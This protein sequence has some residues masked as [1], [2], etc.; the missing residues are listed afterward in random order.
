[1][2]HQSSLKIKTRIAIMATLHTHNLLGRRNTVNGTKLSTEI[3]IVFTTP[4]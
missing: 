2:K 3:M 4:H 1:M